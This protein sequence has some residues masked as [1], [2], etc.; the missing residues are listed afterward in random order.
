MAK[1]LCYLV[2]VFCTISE[3]T[4]KTGIYLCSNGFIVYKLKLKEANTF[5]LKRSDCTSAGIA[6]GTYIVYGDSVS[7]NCN[8]VY[9]LDDKSKRHLINDT[10]SLRYKLFKN[11]NTLVILSP[12]TLMLISKWS[13][14][15]EIKRCKLVKK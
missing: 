6:T 13:S 10:T 4:L 11:S 1:I 7:L 15:N 5:E 2:V 3:N 8:A 9:W 12:D 14:G